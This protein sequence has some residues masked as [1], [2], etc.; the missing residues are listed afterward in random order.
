M[1]EKEQNWAKWLT[2]LRLGRWN[3]LRNRA[4]LEEI[5][6]EAGAKLLASLPRE[7]VEEIKER[8]AE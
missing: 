3:H 1:N 4:G 6:R 2:D 7:T 5:T 8:I